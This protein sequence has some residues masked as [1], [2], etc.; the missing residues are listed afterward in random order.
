MAALRAAAADVPVHVAP[1]L[2]APL[3][4]DAGRTRLLLRNLLDN[5]LRHTPTG[6]A[7]PE[8]HLGVADNGHVL[9]E[10]RDHGPGVPPEQLARLTEAFYRPDD[11]RQR[12][13]GGVGLGLYLARMVAEAHGG[14]L[15]VRNAQPGLA[16]RAEWPAAAVPAES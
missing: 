10:V 11:A 15:T 16:V 1:S 14:R 2:T 8:L 13:T 4:L 12:S 5:A 7:P 9:I 6:A 3:W